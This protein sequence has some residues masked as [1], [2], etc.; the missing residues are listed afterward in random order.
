MQDNSCWN[1]FRNGFKSIIEKHEYYNK[2]YQ[3]MKTAQNNVLLYGTHGFPTDLFIDEVI[4]AK[5]GLDMLYKKECTWNK[6]VIYLYNQY[7]LEIDLLNPMLPKKFTNIIK[8][9]MSIIESRHVINSKHFIIIKH[10][11]VFSRDDFGALR[12]ILERFSN[13]VY[14]LCTTHNLDKIDVP[15]K[16]RFDLIRMPLFQHQE[17]KYIFENFLNTPLNK[18]LQEQET[19]NII[20]AIFI[21]DVE[22]QN[23]ELI[24]KDF[25]TLN[26]PPLMDFV[27]KF[28]K[29][30]NNLESIRALSY[31]IFQ[32][33][34][35]ISDILQDLLKMPSVKNKFKII[36][37][38]SNI[39]HLLQCTNKGREPIY[40]ET[41]L[42]SVFL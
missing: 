39:D 37:E 23:K 34:I 3:Y 38:A 24:T 31:Q 36:Q 17:V 21:A 26:F 10:I 32:Y 8:F 18:Y 25:C 9:L 15:V 41:F 40:I 5:F 20:K 4:K 13:N 6:D 28:D 14:F 42:C 35:T 16:S 27:A 19:R 2:I 22:K 11:D 1:T 30:K 33:N 7:F 29:K 12:I